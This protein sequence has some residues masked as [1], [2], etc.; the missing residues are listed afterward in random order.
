LNAALDHTPTGNSAAPTTA[1]QPSYRELIVFLAA[2]QAMAAAAID[3]ILPSFPE[4]RT[5]LGLAGDSPRVSLLI[6]AFMLGSGF[7]QLP[8]G[9][10]ADRFGRRPVL[11]GGL[12]LYV[13]A[14]VASTLAPN[15][16]TMIACRF[17]WG[18]AASAPRVV[19]MSMVRDRFEGRRMA[20]TL[21]YV[22]AVFVIVP[23]LAPSLGALLLHSGGW[24]WSM[25]GPGVAAA[26]LVVWTLR[27]PESLDRSARRTI[28]PRMIGEAFKTVLRTRR[29]VLLTGTLVCSM[30]L[31]ST[32]IGL[33]ELIT[34]QTYDRK[35]QFP[36]VFGAIAAA[37]AAGGLLNA[38]LVGRF[39][40]TKMLKVT[41]VI[42]LGISAAF[43]A[44]TLANDG[45][46]P[47]WFY[48]ISMAALLAVQT[49]VF[50]NANSA[51][52][53]PLGHIAGLASGLIGTVSTIGGSLIA[54]LIVQSHGAGVTALALGILG[55][56]ACSALCSRL[57]TR[58]DAPAPLS[59][60]AASAVGAQR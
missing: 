16:G 39:G 8:T 18:M 7:A 2:A 42:M 15:L 52:L 24:R 46:P 19:S 55:L 60:Q 54:M 10:L 33:A 28:S 37:M 34:D 27:I 57:S 25:A 23:I 20:Q 1:R 41:P 11:I 5:H 14:A 59:A 30:A 4:V 13:A 44:V 38:N 9:I 53:A 6:T 17:V 22:Q 56:T 43:S 36:V 29:T 12:A 31:V 45:R 48:C 40:T 3:M 32:Y 26:L 35:S 21:S 49:L 58:T 50:P 47:F 51:S